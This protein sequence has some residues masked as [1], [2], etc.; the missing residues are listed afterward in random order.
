MRVFVCARVA[1]ML[2]SPL[3]NSMRV[4]AVS[5]VGSARRVTRVCR[6]TSALPYVLTP[7]YHRSC[8]H[9]WRVSRIWEEVSPAE[10]KVGGCI[11]RQDL[12]G[13]NQGR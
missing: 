11:P 2:V 12:G 1:G 13:R 5:A 3:H 10:K 7:C 6:Q 8:H 4:C 9:Q